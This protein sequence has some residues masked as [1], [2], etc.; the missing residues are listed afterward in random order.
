MSIYLP[1]YKFTPA[2]WLTGNITLCSLE[3]QGVF[4]NICNYY[5]MSDC[6]ICFDLLK[7][8]FKQNEA[9]LNELLNLDIIKKNNN[10]EIVINFLDE[11]MNGFVDLAK[12]RSSAG[13]KGGQARSKQ[14][15]S[16]GKAIP[17][18]LDK[19]REDKIREDKIRENIKKEI[20]EKNLV[21]TLKD[22]VWKRSIKIS[23]AGSDEEYLERVDWWYGNAKQDEKWKANMKKLYPDISYAK[24]FI[25]MRQW[26]LK[27]QKNRKTDLNR[28][29]MGFCQDRYGEYALESLGGLAL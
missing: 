9:S 12:K 19:R 11:Q 27:A 1:Y 5:W 28:T 24:A 4:V 8:R 3:T 14:L 29:Y 26:L 10:G 15:L 18:H 7:Q 13:R 6:S 25:G 23:T 16:K 22:V 21:T 17:K 2:E 20:K